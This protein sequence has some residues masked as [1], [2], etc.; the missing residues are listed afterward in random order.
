MLGKTSDGLTMNP[1]DNYYIH[2]SDSILE[3]DPAQEEPYMS[4]AVHIGACALA[5]SVFRSLGLPEK[6]SAAFGEDAPL[7]ED[8]VL[9]ITLFRAVF[10]QNN[11]TRNIWL[12]TSVPLKNLFSSAIL[13][14]D[15]IIPE[16]L[17]ICQSLRIS[18]I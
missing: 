6:L 13:P 14:R 9:R 10:G 18:F 12:L 17:R 2:F 11:V 4:E 3:E 16:A 5:G 7:I 15:M 1:N 8:L